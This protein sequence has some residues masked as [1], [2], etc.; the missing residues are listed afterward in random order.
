MSDESTPASAADGRFVWHDLRTPAP[1]AA[2]AFYGALFGWDIRDIPMPH[3]TYRMISD[4]PPEEGGQGLGGI[5]DLAQEE[6]A[7]AHWIGYVTVADVDAATQAATEAGGQVHVPPTDIPEVGRFSV[8]ADPSGGVVAPFRSASGDLPEPEGPPPPGH[9]CWD[10]LVSTDAAACE[11]FYPNLFPW[12]VESMTMPSGPGMP[13]FTYHLFRRGEGEGATDR[14]GMLQ[15]PPEAE[16][17]SHWIPYVAV[18]DVDATCEQ[19]TALGATI[20]K[21][22]DDIPQ[23]GRFAVLGDP[24]GAT[25]AVWKPLAQE[26]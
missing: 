26:G 24:Q 3:G 2:K 12:R 16:A 5:E 4:R 17:P 9:F 14:A 25:F 10:E 18:E 20:H 8:V 1:D 19:A 23:M 11:G 15:M 21:Q 7:P 6:G 13:E 22:P